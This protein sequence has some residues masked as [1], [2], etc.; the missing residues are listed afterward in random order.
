M[1]LADVAVIWRMVMQRSS[2]DDMVDTI[3]G[4]V[5]S[6]ADDVVSRPSMAPSLSELDCLAASAHALFSRDGV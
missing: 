6:R 3:G 1:T 5:D 2:E 4:S